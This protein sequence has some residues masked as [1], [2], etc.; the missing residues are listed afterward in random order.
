MTGRRGRKEKQSRDKHNE[1]DEQDMKMTRDVE[2][3][4]IVVYKNGVSK[5]RRRYI[6]GSKSSISH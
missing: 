4:G 1:Q 5:T 6:S 2:N 3:N